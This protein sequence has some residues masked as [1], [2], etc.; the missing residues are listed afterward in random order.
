MNLLIKSAKWGFVLVL[1]VVAVS[2]GYFFY[3]VLSFDTETLPENHGK[4]NAQLYLGDGYNQ[5]LI[6]GFGGAEGGNTWARHYWKPLRD[7]WLSQGYAILAVGYFGMEGIPKDVDRIALEG[8]HRAVLEAAGHP[9]IN[10]E[11]IAL[12]GGSKGA[13]LALALASHYPE[14][15]AVAGIVPGHAV[16]AA[17]TLAMSTSSFSLNGQPLP[18]VPVPWSATPAL[19]KR[20]LRGAWEKMLEDEE[21]VEKAAIHVENING[22][23]FLLSATRDEFWPSAEMSELIMQRLQANGFA[24]HAEHIAIDGDHGAP[25]NHLDEVEDFLN[26][27]FMSG[28]PSGCPRS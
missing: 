22:P 2:I 20:D 21:A 9:R 14:Y 10:G 23:V 7:E 4:V 18:F 5:P 17:Q 3:L 28:N 13:E 25:L 16:F 19:I 15:K 8:V 6:V 26:A 27:H 1:G 11:C 12:V 24:Y